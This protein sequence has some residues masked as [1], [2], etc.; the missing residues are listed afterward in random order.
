MDDR[1]SR[2]GFNNSYFSEIICS[3]RVVMYIDG[4]DL[5]KKMPNL[6]CYS[7]SVEVLPKLAIML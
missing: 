5:Y 1:S 6:F 4:H 2:K 7:Y 3:S